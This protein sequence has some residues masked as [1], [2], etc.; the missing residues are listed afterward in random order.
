MQLF[1]RDVLRSLEAG[2]V[3][4]LLIQTVRHVFA[5]LYAHASSADLVERVPNPDT[6]SD[7]PG[8][9]KLATAQGEIAT[10]I[11]LLLLPLLALII[12]RWGI[13]FPLTVILAALGRSMALQVPDLEVPMASLA[14]GAGLLYLA[15]V[16]ARRPAHFPT[17][18][19]AG[20]AA[21]QVSRALGDT[22][23]RTWQSDY[24][25]RF[26]D[27]FEPDM[28]LLVSITAV[29]LI[30][31]SIV[32]W[33]IERR[34]ELRE[35][36]EEGYAPPLRGLLDTWGGLALGG[37]FFIEFTLLSL[38][39]AVARW[40]GTDYAGLV[41]WLLAATTLPL[42][43]EV[44]DVARRFAGMFD[45]A[46]RGWFWVL[47]I[48]LLLVIGRGYDG[49]LAG[50]ALVFAQFFVGLTLWWLV[51]TGLPRRNFTGL[52]VLFAV[53]TFAVLA[54]G[55][56][57]TYDYAYVRNL[58][59]PYQNVGD[60]LRAFRD[61]GLGLTLIAVLLL[62][63]PM[64][65]ARRRIPWRGG[66]AGHT[67][68]VLALVLGVSFAGAAIVGNTVVRRPPN[69]DCMRVATYNIHGGYSQFFDPNLDGVAEIIELAGA[70]VVLLQE[71][72]AGRLVSF[73]IDQPYWLARR[74]QMEHTFFPQNEALQGLAVLSRVPI[75][76]MEG[77]L[78]PS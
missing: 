8:V 56:Y 9:V 53:V 22:Y 19:L 1:R 41:P 60:V 66:P 4:L 58:S 17:V 42:V 14:A 29:L 36:Q 18:I 2:I 57:F 62:S 12:S 51:Q 44:R 33:Y 20:F 40:S 75:V 74:L 31:L 6:L 35:R 43:P 63:I 7:V 11:A 28:G 71:V 32:L 16:I 46:W 64:I 25:V 73:G 39:N 50:V 68:L 15:L 59:D 30:L 24:V 78:L 10:L 38:P 76:D 54:T 72:D 27:G 21:D 49:L 37:I 26:A 52:T 77:L 3:G 5:T 61:M 55:D 34:Q 70:D 48:S 67:L 13:S 45:S 65:L 69:P 47:L 23:D